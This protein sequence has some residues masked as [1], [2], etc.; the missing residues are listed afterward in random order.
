MKKGKVHLINYSH[1]GKTVCGIST[2]MNITF[3]TF[4]EVISCLKCKQ[5]K[6]YLERKYLYG[7][8]E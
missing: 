8:R 4:P 1:D 3:S 2:L 5:T 6:I 7:G